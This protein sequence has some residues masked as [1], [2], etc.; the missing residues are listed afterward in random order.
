M[1]IQAALAG[2]AFAFAA[3]TASG[4]LRG[5]P[6]TVLTL[7]HYAGRLRYVE[8]TS[9]TAARLLFDT[10]GGITLLS[11]D[12]ARSM[13]CVPYTTL[14]GFRMNGERFDAEGCGSTRLAFGSLDLSPDVAVF[15]LMSLLPSELPAL[16]G[17][18]SLQTFRDHVVT[19]D[20]ANDTLTIA[21]ELSPGKVR[22]LT[23]IGVR[24]A[25]PFAGAGLDA[26]IRVTGTQGP[27]WFELDS[28]NVDAVLISRRV[29]DQLALPPGVLSSL[30][31]GSITRV[32]IP[33]EG[34]GSIQLPAKAADIIYDG[35]LNAESLERMEIVLDL[36]RSLGWA[37]RNNE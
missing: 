11:P 14:T 28:G 3:C 18:A 23:P 26:F 12:S 5:S 7:H 1:R 13:G 15:D 16:D 32:P 8:S 29:I 24:L 34:L 36:E 2:V 17:L 19:L 25:R 35:V 21:D 20:F 31:A 9:P 10:A 4:P 27:L 22:G 33:V 30:R 6:D 37:G